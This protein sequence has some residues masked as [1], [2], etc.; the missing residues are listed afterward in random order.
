MPRR[1][2][3]AIAMLSL[4][5]PFGFFGLRASAQ[6]VK[7]DYG[8]TT[9]T[10]H[11]EIFGGNR[12]P[13]DPTVAQQVVDAGVTLT[14]NDYYLE[15]IVPTSTVADYKDN[16]GN[17]QDPGTWKWGA[18]I[19]LVQSQAAKSMDLKILMIISYN[20]P[21]NSYSGT[22]YGVPKDWWV[23][24]DIVKKIYL[25]FPAD[26]VEVWNE[27]DITQYFDITGSPYSTPQAGYQDIYY[28]AARA[29]RSVDAHVPIGGPVICCQSPRDWIPSFLNDPRIPAS[30]INFLSY[31]K[32]GTDNFEDPTVVNLAAAN[33]RP[34]IPVYMTEWNANDPSNADAPEMVSFV[35]MRLS[36]MLNLGLSGANL[37][38]IQDL[39]SSK[40]AFYSRGQL[41][42]TARTWLLMSKKLGM[43][44]DLSKIKK[45]TWSRVTTAV[46]AVNSSGQRILTVVNHSRRAVNVAVTL[47]N[48][49]L[50]GDVTLQVYRASSNDDAQNPIETLTRTVVNNSVSLTISMPAYS[51]AGLIVSGT[52]PTPIPSPSPIP[53]RRLFAPAAPTPLP[54]PMPFRN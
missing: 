16:V 6:S 9:G 20:T 4:S 26:M 51:V 24:E 30:W 25:H 11:P 18:N 48:L 22:R 13:T 34:H 10:G 8:T 32:Y 14:R 33:G 31:H 46:G 21:W 35:G 19:L 28:H 12:F 42:P 37:F 44:A 27:P 23:Y 45:T 52:S 41:L 39:A 38:A 17:I 53:L 29:I 2:F 5:A 43:G 47:K 36:N 15:K 1:K 3:I 40:W 49:G 7:V 54:R 50:S